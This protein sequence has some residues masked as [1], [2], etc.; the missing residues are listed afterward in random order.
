MVICGRLLLE[1]KERNSMRT[2]I[3]ALAAVLASGTAG[4]IAR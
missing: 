2:M 4:R 1:Q 3:L